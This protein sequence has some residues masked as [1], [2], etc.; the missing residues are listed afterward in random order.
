M[1]GQAS[2]EIDFADFMSCAPSDKSHIVLKRFEGM[3]P[4]KPMY[5]CAKKRTP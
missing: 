4:S 1:N 3:A 2:M 5:P